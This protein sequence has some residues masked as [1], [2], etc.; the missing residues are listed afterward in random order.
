MFIFFFGQNQE[1]RTTSMNTHNLSMFPF[2]QWNQRELHK[3]H[4]LDKQL[5]LPQIYGIN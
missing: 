5:A 1:N 2:L 4:Y 3:C